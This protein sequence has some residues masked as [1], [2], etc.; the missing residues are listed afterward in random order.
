MLEPRAG[1]VKLSRPL[2]DCG[3]IGETG[4]DSVLLRSFSALDLS[5]LAALENRDPALD[6]AAY[7][8]LLDDALGYLRDE[9]D[10][11]GFEPRVGWIHGT[12][13]VRESI[14]ATLG[15]IRR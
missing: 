12:Q 9:R 11:R 10:L 8:K 4:T 2:P 7:R 1:A 5:I 3:G 6:D 14:L 13:A 15:R